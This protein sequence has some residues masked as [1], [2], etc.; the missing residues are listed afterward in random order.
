[1]AAN[2]LEELRSRHAKAEA[3]GG[4]ERN[5]RQH[6]DGKLSARERLELA[7]ATSAWKET[8][9]MAMAS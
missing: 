1:M 2:R 3:G 9:L 7:A 5:E 6:K 4:A 8:W